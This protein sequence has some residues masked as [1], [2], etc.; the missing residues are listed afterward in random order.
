MTGHARPLAGLTVAVVGSTPVASASAALFTLLGATTTVF[1]RPE[2]NPRKTHE[3][4]LVRLLL[5]GSSTV[6]VPDTFDPSVLARAAT[7]DVVIADL[8]CDK[9]VVNSTFIDEYRAAVARCNRAVWVSVSGFGIE[10]DMRTYRSTEIT[11]LASGGIPFYM[12]DESGRPT[13]PAGYTASIAAGHLAALAGLFGLVG[14]GIS[15]PQHFDLSMQ[16]SVVTTGVFLECAHILF[17]SPGKGGMG[18]YAAPRGYF[19]CSDGYVFVV[20]LEDHQWQGVVEALGHPLW[21]V[22]IT[23]NAD[24]LEHAT[25]I[26]EEIRAWAKPL[27]ASDC[28]DLLQ[29]HGVPA[30]RMNACADL[31]GDVD[32]Q[33]DGFFVST[34]DDSEVIPGLPATLQAQADEGRHPAEIGRRIRVL[35]VGNVLAGPLATSWLGTMGLDVLKVED[36]TRLDIYRRRGP[37]IEGGDDVEHGAYFAAAN[38]SKRSCS[39]ELDSPEGRKRLRELMSES[40]F[41]VENLSS[42]RA[43]RIGLTSNVVNE[44]GVTLISSS[45]FGRSSTKSAYRAYGQIIHSFGGITY[46]TR[47]TDGKFRALGTSWADPLTSTWISIL[48][49]AQLYDASGHRYHVDL[50]MVKVVGRELPEYFA[51]AS[52]GHTTKWAG[53][54]RLDGYAP[55]GIYRARGDDQWVAMAIEDELEWQE[56]LR[57]VDDRRLEGPQFETSELRQANAKELDVMLDTV[58]SQHDADRM[59]ERLQTAGVACS[60]VYGAR[61]LA[62]SQ[63]LRDR[64]LI[65]TV[66]HPVWG[67]RDV[68]GLPWRVVGEGPLPVGL[69]PTLGN[70]DGY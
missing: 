61:N 56:F 13:K 19:R 29:R 40:D 51:A 17:N 58:L 4:E 38:F 55:H 14:R 41:V 54:N 53:A 66:D 5:A 52:R 8:S 36:P 21:A 2:H 27:R 64:G 68:T 22:E 23:S 48:I 45:G 16:D 60:P 44:L 34:G 32:F 20:V 28:A 30:S 57:V 12:R 70:A 10:S 25:I 47:D 39:F 37:F 50:S 43:Q 35:D 46:E 62:E 11:A 6:E 67:K 3:N 1:M 33:N 7:A 49:L 9:R 42:S 24:R 65:Q 63:H 15:A 18:R 59:M 31:L 69:T 26:D